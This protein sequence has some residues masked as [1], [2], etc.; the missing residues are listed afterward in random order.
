MQKK[1]RFQPSNKVSKD[2]KTRRENIATTFGV[3]SRSRDFH[4]ACPS[5]LDRS[6]SNH[7]HPLPDLCVSRLA[8][9]GEGG[10]SEAL[11]WDT[12][13]RSCAPLLEWF[14]AS[15]AEK[16]RHDGDHSETEIS[17]FLALL[18]V[19][20]HKLIMEV[21][22]DPSYPRS[23]RDIYHIY[24]CKC[25]ESVDRIIHAELFEFEIIEFS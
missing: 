23:W 3:V 15:A 11:I 9:R 16:I 14:H 1:H 24:L 20:L 18:H 5:P 25:I 13:S 6:R 22:Q 19:K 7:G 8:S 21:I 10:K 2:S 12:V 4:E 17:L